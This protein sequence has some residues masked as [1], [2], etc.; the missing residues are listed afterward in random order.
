MEIEFDEEVF[1]IRKN[2]LYAY[3][4]EEKEVVVP[5]GVGTVNAKFN[6]NVERIV[7]PDSVECIGIGAFSKCKNLKSLVVNKKLVWHVFDTN[8]W[9]GEVEVLRKLGPYDEEGDDAFAAI[10]LPSYAKDYSIWGIPLG[11][12]CIKTFL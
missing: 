12:K 7:L 9:N 8:D 3:Y 2:T 6:Q 1:D 11:K 10:D 4:G 5:D